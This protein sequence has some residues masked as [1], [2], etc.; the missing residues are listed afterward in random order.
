MRTGSSERL[1]G[2]AGGEV[3]FP[4][5]EVSFLPSATMADG[6]IGSPR[7]Q[8]GAAPGL[9][10]AVRFTIPCGETTLAGRLFAR[11]EGN[12]TLRLRYE[13]E[14][15][16]AIELETLEVVCRLD[17]RRWRGGAYRFLDGFSGVF[18][19]PGHGFGLSAIDKELSVST[20]SGDFTFSLSRRDHGPV[21]LSYEIVDDE[22]F[23]RI[24]LPLAKGP[25]APGGTVSLSFAI[26]SGDAIE[27]TPY[28]GPVTIVP[29]AG[30]TPLSGPRAILPGSPLDFSTLGTLDAP[31]G[32]HGRLVARGED[33][34]FEDLPGKRQR[35]YGVNTCAGANLL[36]LEEARAFAGRL[37][38]IGYNS[39]R[40]HHHDG[41]LV[42]AGKR[43]L[44]MDEEALATLDNLVFACEERGIY[45]STDLYVSRSIPYR[46]I[47]IDRD[48]VVGMQE[49]KMLLPVS[50][51]AFD[52]LRAFTRGFLG[53]V[54]RHT[55]VRYADD[56]AIAWISFVNEGN[57]GNMGGG[58]FRKEPLW[59]AAWAKWLGEKKRIAPETYRDIT[60]EVPPGDLAIRSRQNVAFTRFLTEMETRFARRMTS[61]V[62]D[63][64]GCRALFTNFNGWFP[65]SCYQEPRQ[66]VYDYV[67][68]HF[69]IDHPSFLEKP[70]ELPSQCPN[71]NP[72]R[73]A[74]DGVPSVVVS[75]I[76]GKPFTISEYNYSAPGRYRGVGG[77]ATGAMAALQNWA[78]TWRFAWSHCHDG[79]SDPDHAKTG[80]FDVSGDPLTLAAERAS[81]CLFL[82]GDLQP[83]RKSYL[84]RIPPCDDAR[85]GADPLNMG[86]FCRMAWFRRFGTIVS[87]RIPEGYDYAGSSE[88]DYRKPADLLEEECLRRE[89]IGAFRGPV[90]IDRG[91]GTFSIT[92]ERTAGGFAEAGRIEA[93]PLSVDLSVAPATVWA[94]S[95][96]DS[97]IHASRRILVTH[98]TDV[99]NSSIRYADEK[100]QVLLDWGELPHLMRNGRAEISLG[101]DEPG[102]YEV[103]LLSTDGSTRRAIPFR[104][105]G[106][107]LLFTAETGRDPSEA[108]FLY[109]VVRKDD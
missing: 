25:L 47:G 101:L 53:H 98:L 22:E 39:L 52:N 82:R 109:L 80:Y 87:D 3:A 75:R 102:A 73:N 34:E 26:R 5:H 48:G 83:H 7:L 41:L 16:R 72:L 36:T 88:D 92:T 46:D 105:E 17:C 78:G 30:W 81:L 79:C 51:A 85:L 37:A 54:N 40:I 29:S 9:D 59:R 71:V 76:Y 18:P 6:V 93:G 12:E 56:P 65:P 42:R 107:R 32:K 94:S 74:W 38:R 60:D 33:F 13:V 58:A 8:D 77:I 64:I 4:R 96:D 99:Q 20:P 104:A 10:G 61:L 69:Y 91:K 68:N 2:F 35:F 95:L 62:R 90:S 86:D 21:R 28:D 11:P 89:G 27:W 97:P 50:D 100:L 31:A 43:P 70:W 24:R 15:D 19:E 44:E 23:L 106:D 55:G 103:R 1:Q 63:E 49:Y 66:D 14:A 84:F 45:L 108:S 67:D 57:L